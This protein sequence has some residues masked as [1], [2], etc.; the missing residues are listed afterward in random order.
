MTRRHLHADYH[1]SMCGK[2]ISHLLATWD[3]AEA[4]CA[5]CRK[6][7][8]IVRA[9]IAAEEA[10]QAAAA[11]AKRQQR[12]EEALRREEAKLLR[13]MARVASM[14]AGKAA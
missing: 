2:D 9:K 13:H 10:R 4:D 1:R 11:E 7:A 14:R 6:Q 3:E 8:P 12:E 5:V